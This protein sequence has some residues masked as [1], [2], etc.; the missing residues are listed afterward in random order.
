MVSSKP[1]G[2]EEYAVTLKWS[3]KREIIRTLVK[4][5]ELAAEQGQVVCRIDAFLGAGDPEKKSLQL[6]KRSKQSRA[7]KHLPALCV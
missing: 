4:R 5:G 7:G 1:T 6:C 2:G 3:R